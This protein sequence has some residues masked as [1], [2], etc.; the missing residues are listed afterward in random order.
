MC[1][2]TLKKHVTNNSWVFNQKGPDSS[3]QPSIN[4]Q[5]VLEKRIRSAKTYHG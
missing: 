5:D 4:R 3:L 2:S 1:A